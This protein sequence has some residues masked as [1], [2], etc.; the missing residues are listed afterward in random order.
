MPDSSR[1]ILRHQD[2]PAASVEA[3]FL[4]GDLTMKL[5]VAAA[6]DIHKPAKLLRYCDLKEKHGI[7]FSCRLC[8][9]KTLSELM[10]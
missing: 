1:V 4:L 2:Q 7:T 9:P 5:A 3:A 6:N 10:T 8:V